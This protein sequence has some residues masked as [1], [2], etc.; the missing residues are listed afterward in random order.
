MSNRSW[1]PPGRSDTHAQLVDAEDSQVEAQ[2]QPDLDPRTPTLRRRQLDDEPY[3]PG[4]TSGGQR[5]VPSKTPK[6]RKTASS[7][8]SYVKQNVIWEAATVRG[9]PA[10]DARPLC[11]IS[12]A[13]DK[14]TV[15]EYS[16]VASG[17]TPPNEVI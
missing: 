16:H 4:T 3:I 14:M 6:R 11:F 9:A 5:D 1:T 12:G 2:L 15:I 17:S 8:P 7:L 13:S 10:E